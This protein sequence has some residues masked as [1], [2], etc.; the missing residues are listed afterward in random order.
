MKK[1]IRCKK[2]YVSNNKHDLCYSCFKKQQKEDSKLNTE[3]HFEMGLL[4]NEVY[5][6]YIMFYGR[7]DKIG[8]TND[9][10]SRL[11]EIKRKYPE[12]KLVYFREFS[13]QSEARVFEAWLKKLTNREL[14][15]FV[16]N[17]QDKIKKVK[18]F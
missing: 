18:S 1:C 2:N 8:Y 10:N 11:I 16:S 15:K 17:F 5:T 14:M 4:M 12:N 6:V 9:L 7:K 13:K 3:D